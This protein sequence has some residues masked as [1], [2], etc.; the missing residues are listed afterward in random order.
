MSPSSSTRW[1]RSGSS[2]RRRA[3]LPLAARAEE[4][5]ALPLHQTPDRGAAAPARL[6]LAVVDPRA[7]LELAGV[8]NCADADAQA[9]AT[10]ANRGTQR[11]LDGLLEPRKARASL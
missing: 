4:R 3:D 6:P 11:A 9:R 2:R 10:S 7:A 5:R 1:W 8:S